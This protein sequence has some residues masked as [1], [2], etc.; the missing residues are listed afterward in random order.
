MTTRSQYHLHPVLVIYP[1][2]LN[3]F[4]WLTQDLNCAVTANGTVPYSAGGLP[5]SDGVHASPGCDPCFLL[6]TVKT[7]TKQQ[8]CELYTKMCIQTLTAVAQW[9]RSPDCIAVL[10]SKSVLAGLAQW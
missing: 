1:L 5:T 8:V 4:I 10:G 7:H 3:V 2:F 6:T 9:F